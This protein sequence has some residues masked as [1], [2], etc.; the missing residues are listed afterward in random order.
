MWVRIQLWRGVFDTTF[1]DKVCQWLST[2]RWFSPCPLVSS[3]NKTDHHDINNILLKVALNTIS[4]PTTDMR[5][6]VITIWSFPHSWLITGATLEQELP[7]HLSSLA[8]FSDD[9]VARSLVFC[10][11]FIDHCLSF[12]TFSFGYCIVGPSSI[13]GFWL[14]LWYFQ[15]FL[16]TYFAGWYVCIDDRIVYND[17]WEQHLTHWYD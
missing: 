4:Q 2:C 7:E 1:C 8:V 9:R 11:C 16:M 14:P 6:L 12:C 17:S 3:T 15:T 10:V 13:Y 5:P